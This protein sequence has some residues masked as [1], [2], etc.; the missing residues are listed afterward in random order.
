MEHP[1]TMAAIIYR[2]LLAHHQLWWNGVKRDETMDS[3]TSG[4][5]ESQKAITD[6]RT[7]IANTPTTKWHQDWRKALRWAKRRLPSLQ[8]DVID[9]VALEIRVAHTRIMNPTR[10]E[11][12]GLI[13]SPLTPPDP[14]GSRR[15]KNNDADTRLG[16]TLNP[17]NEYGTPQTERRITLVSQ[18]PEESTPCLTNIHPPKQTHTH[19]RNIEPIRPILILGD[20][21]IELLPCTI[22]E[23][24]VEVLPGTKLYDAIRI[25][26]R[27]TPTSPYVRKVILSFGLDDREQKYIITLKKQLHQLLY[28]AHKTF[29]NAEV[30]IPVINFSSNLPYHMKRTILTM[31]HLI[32]DTSHAIPR[33]PQQQFQTKVDNIQ[34]TTH[35]AEHIWE[36][37]KQHLN[38]QDKTQT[39]SLSHIVNLSNLHLTKAQIDLLSKGLS[40]VPTWNT[41]KDMRRRLTL[42]VTQ[43]HRKLKLIAHYGSNPDDQQNRL[44]FLSPSLWEPETDKLPPE[45]LQLIKTD[46]EQLPHLIPKPENPNLTS[47][48]VEALQHLLCNNSI[49]V[50]P[51]DK[52]GKVVIMNRTD[53]IKEGYRQLDDPKYY[54][55]LSTPIYHTTATQISTILDSLKKSR[56]LNSKQIEYLKGDPN[57]KPRRFYLLPKIHK[58]PETWPVPFLIPSGR[59]I[60]SDCGSESYRTAEFIDFFL[61]PLSTKHNSYLRDTKHFVEKVRSITLKEPCFLFSMDVE[62]L[63]TNIDTHKGMEIIQHCLKKHPDPTRPDRELLHLLHINLTKNDFEFNGEYFLQLSGTAMGK[64]F[65]PSYANI[66]MAHWEETA[67]LKCPLLPLQYLRYLDDIW[68]VWQHTPKEFDDFI[69]ILNSHHPDIKLKATF[70]KDSIDFLDTTTFKGPEFAKTGTLDIRVFV[71]PTDTQTLLHRRSFHPTH[72][73]KGILKSQILRFKRICTRES[74]C[75]EAERRL[76]LSLKK[77]GYSWSFMRRIKRDTFV[78]KRLEGRETPPDKILIPII[79]TYSPFTQQATLKIKENFTRILGNSTVFQQHRPIAAFRKNPNLKDLLVRAKLPRMTTQ[80]R[81]AK[82][83]RIIR[84]TTKGKAIAIPY[85][86]PH[87]TPNC[88][89]LLRCN[90]CQILYVGE[91]RNPLATRLTNHRQTIRNH[92]TLKTHLVI[93]FRRH[94]V[95]NIHAIILEHN[96]KWSTKQRRHKEY[97]WIKRL[98]TIFPKGLN[99]RLQLTH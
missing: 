96:P 64:K 23:A 54:C 73:F 99:E 14:T 10:E 15:T 32:R 41:G 35:T 70:R 46:S 17:G 71:K 44:P 33:I 63:Y 60:V 20:C 19:I 92:P 75:I 45:L 5:S 95:N 81:P 26:R 87:A 65:A 22:P 8:Q 57:P 85:A 31:N 21:N 16:E 37:W 13:P 55:K 11:E 34:W 59:P 83:N 58:P 7:T 79:T 12:V 42:D 89:Y 28:V 86:L 1:T 30:F 90:L 68:G 18:T 27:G 3:P 98:G 50:K 49:V 67:F 36:H 48:E 78:K 56:T 47:E 80:T 77:R 24:Q 51:A 82:Q 6:C 61:N 93:H 76:F 74:D 53:Y 91:T 69:E 94:G 25:L 97:Q 4:I 66:Y 39:Q 88:V 38:I 9:K 2:L 84:T 29:P 40:F 43:Y 72:T 62:S 52:G